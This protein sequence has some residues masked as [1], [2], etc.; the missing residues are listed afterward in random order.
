MP[1]PKELFTAL[2]LPLMSVM[3]RDADIK[4]VD[5]GGRGSAF[6]PLITLAPFAEYFVAEPDPSE[7][8]RLSSLLPAEAPWRGVVV[9]DSAIA[10]RAGRSVL[11]V[12]AEPGMSSLLEPDPVIAGTFQLARKFNVV[13]EL[14][15]ATMPLDAAAVR[16]GFADAAFLKLDTQGT[17]LDIL[18]SGRELVSGP[19]VGVAIEASFHAFY[20][21]QP[22]FADIDSHLR[23]FGFML[24]SLDRT[25]LRRAGY[26]PSLYSKRVV[27]WAHC[28][29]LRQPAALIAGGTV[30][31]RRRVARAL[32]V[33]VAFQHFDLAFEIVDLANRCALLSGADAAALGS[34]LERAADLSLRYLTHKLRERETTSLVEELTAAS[35]RDRSRRE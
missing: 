33:A 28:L 34:E 16:Y 2:D 8:D 3:L 5:I 12:T 22:L 32:G 29:Y 18:E 21:G 6:Y 1:L 19:L 17:E 35:V 26:R 4:L 15:V 11:H 13:S 20:K 10:S 27:S 30:S 9:F 24:C 14:D 7:A 31:S 23:G 25:L